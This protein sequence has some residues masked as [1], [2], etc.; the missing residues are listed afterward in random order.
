MG[1]L[2]FGNK[3]AI[4]FPVMRSPGEL[5]FTVTAVITPAS[6]ARALGGSA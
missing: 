1:A 4:G 6:S 2:A 3:R 5:A